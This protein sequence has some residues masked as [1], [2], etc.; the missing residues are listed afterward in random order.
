MVMLLY[1]KDDYADESEDKDTVE[2][3][4]AKNRHGETGIGK[5][6]WIGKYTRFLSIDTQR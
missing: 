3:I 6:R 2:C 1:K 5:L 4:V